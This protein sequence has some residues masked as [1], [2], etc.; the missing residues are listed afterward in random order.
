[1]SFCMLWLWFSYWLRN[2]CWLANSQA[3]YISRATRLGE[4]WE[5]ERQEAK[6][7]EMSCS[8]QE[9]RI[10]TKST[11][12]PKRNPNSA[13]CLNVRLG[14]NIRAF[15]KRF[16]LYFFK[17][18]HKLFSWILSLYILFLSIIKKF[19]DNFMY[20]SFPPMNHK[21]MF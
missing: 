11:Q 16:Q 1:M 6:K 10:D 13:F 2:K 8:H 17:Q 20:K 9:G 7:R 14:T 12:K 21:I 3:G 4:F 5:E 18:L 15:T 19:P